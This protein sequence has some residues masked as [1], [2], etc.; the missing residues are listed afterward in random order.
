MVRLEQQRAADLVILSQ[1]GTS[2]NSSL[3]ILLCS[4]HHFAP[5]LVNDRIQNLVEEEA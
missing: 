3:L 4:A 5:R 1:R 2:V